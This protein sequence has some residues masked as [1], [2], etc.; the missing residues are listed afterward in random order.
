MAAHLETITA[1]Q[2]QVIGQ[3]G[4]LMSEQG[5]YLAGGTAV[6]LHLGHR[7]SDDLDWFSQASI[8]DPLRLAQEIRATDASFNVVS[9]DRGTL[10]GETDSVRISVLEYQYPLLEPPATPH[11]LGCQLASLP[12]LAAMKLVAISQRGSKK[13]FV[14]VYAL[15]LSTMPLAKM[16]ELY[17]HKY[18]IQDAGRMIYS[19]SYFD[20]ADPEPMPEMLWNVKWDDIKQT[21]RE[22]VSATSV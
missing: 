18:S 22:W 13:D 14:D 6:A 17:Q 15:G 8:Q 3:L 12:D 7:R 1:A 4:P 11:G 19:L 20:D 16:L 9:V 21:I 10:H 2:R 5:M